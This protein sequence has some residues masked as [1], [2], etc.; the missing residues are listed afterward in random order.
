VRRL[1]VGKYSR[2]SLR[3]GY[4]MNALCFEN[5][6]NGEENGLR[7]VGVSKKSMIYESHLGI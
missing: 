2:L 1:E 4:P 7:A 3:Q 5:K 6:L